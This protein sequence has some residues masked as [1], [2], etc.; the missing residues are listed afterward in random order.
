MFKRGEER[1][2]SI[3]WFVVIVVVAGAIVL[4]TLGFFSKETDTKEYEAGIL[5]ERIMECLV[6]NGQ[7]RN[8]FGE[9]FDIFKECKLKQEVFAENSLFYFEISL[10]NKPVLFGGDRSMK[11]DCNVKQGTQVKSFPGCVDQSELVLY[12]IDGKT[13]NATIQVLTASNQNSLAYMGAND[14]Q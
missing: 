3:W 2:F 1:M 8:D 6:Q 14:E 5:H 9:G 10:D 13:R 11:A 12:S 4:A 7:L